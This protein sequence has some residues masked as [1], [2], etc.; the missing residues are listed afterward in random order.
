LYLLFFLPQLLCFLIFAFSWREIAYNACPMPKLPPIKSPQ[1]ERSEG[2]NASA[3][4]ICGG[5]F[6]AR[7]GAVA[8]SICVATP[9]C[10]SAAAYVFSIMV[11]VIPSAHGCAFCFSLSNDFYFHYGYFQ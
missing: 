3:A 8:R 6:P 7:H 2:A 4:A 10:I 11:N 5:D 1:C 9:I